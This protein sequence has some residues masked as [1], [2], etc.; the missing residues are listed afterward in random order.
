MIAHQLD[1]YRLLIACMSRGA[2]WRQTEQVSFLVADLMRESFAHLID[3]PLRLKHASFT[4]EAVVEALLHRTSLFAY[5]PAR[6]P[7]GRRDHG[8]PDEV[9][10]ATGAARDLARLSD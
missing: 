4:V 10:R 7:A 3:D 6:L 9:S 1:L 5:R 2:H 8:D